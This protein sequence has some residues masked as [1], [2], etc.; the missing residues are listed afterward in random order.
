MRIEQLEYLAAV[1]EHGSL[2][3]ASEAMHI[4]QPAL[5]EAVTKLEK[6]LGTTLLDRRRTGSRISRQ[7]LDLLQSMTEVL[8]AVD[9]LRQAAGQQSARRRDLRIGTVNTASTSLLAPALRDLHA[10]H[11]SGGVEVV[12]ARQA[13]IQQ[14]L[15]EGSL[16]LGLVNVLP[17]D[18]VSPSLVADR[19]IEGTPVA[20]LRAD[21]PLAAQERLS[22]DDLRSEPHVL[23]RPGYVMHRYAHKLFGGTMPG[24]TY[25]NDG[26]EMG[27]AMVA[28]GLGISILPDFSIAADP[29]VRAGVLT[30]RP[31]ATDQTTVTLLMLR[32][33][34]DRVPEPVRDLQTALVR[35]ARAYVA[36]AEPETATPDLALAS[37]VTPISSARARSAQ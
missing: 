24:T 17:G 26:A 25:A 16:D 35:Q 12:N 33:R 31:I 14:G 21:H 34:A 8:E 11:G 13:D 15:V 22:V 5:S 9:R 29:L 18:E 10:R 32:R 23:M 1:T 20:C 7:G 36:A 27:K 4:S 37:T 6:E 30:T 3:R 19:L 2:R 28:A